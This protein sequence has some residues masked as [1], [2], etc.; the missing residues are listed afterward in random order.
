MSNELELKLAISPSDHR[1]LLAHPVLRTATNRTD[2][3]LDNSYFDTP[4]LALRRRGI[5]LRLRKLGRL[6]LTPSDISEAQRG[7]ALLAGV[8]VAS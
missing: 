8:A 7:Y 3:M 5:A 2:Q 4:D 6:R 1:R